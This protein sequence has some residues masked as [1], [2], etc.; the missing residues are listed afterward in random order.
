MLPYFNAIWGESPKIKQLKIYYLFMH[1]DGECK[2]SEV[3]FLDEIIAKSE[4]DKSELD[5]F[6]EFC[7]KMQIADMGH[8]ASV[9]IAEI[10]K[11]L[12]EKEESFTLGTTYPFSKNKRRDIRD[13]KMQAQTIW[14]L[15]NLGY[16]DSKYSEEEKK[17][18]NHLV[19]RWKMDSMLV[20]ELNDTAATILDLTLQKE[21]IQTTSKPYKEINNII[22]EL[23]RNIDSMFANVEIAIS[24]ADIEKE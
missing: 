4:L 8:S 16:A 17:V 1:A 2:K 19:E 9:A 21:W 6:I 14:T 22:Q 20:A 12:G 15:I 3:G 11:L 23:D 10:D 13:K 18:V 7:G 5:E 24:E